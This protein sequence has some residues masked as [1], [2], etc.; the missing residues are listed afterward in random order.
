[1]QSTVDLLKSASNAYYN[2]EEPIMDDDTFDALVDQ[3]REKDPKNPFLKTVG[4]PP[5][6]GV[7]KLPALMPS[8]EKI[9]PGE[10]TLTRFLNLSRDY[11]I[12]EK[13]DGLSALWCPATKG[14]FL[15]GDGVNGQTISHIAPSISSL[16][17]SGEP[18]IIRGELVLRKDAVGL[19][20][21]P[22]RT[23]INGLVHKS[24]PDPALLSQVK[25]LAYEVISP[26]GMKRS[27]QFVWLQGEGFMVP[28]WMGVR[29]T[30][31][32]LK[33]LFTVRRASS[34]YD[35]DG[36][37]VGIDRIP[38]KT[39]TS[40]KPPKDCV[41]FK[42]PVSDQ[43]AITTVEEV[44]WAPSA[45]GYLIPRIRIQPVQIGGARIEFCTGHNARTIVDKGIGPGA[46][47]KVRRS[48]DVIPTL[49]SV[50]LGVNGSLP[51]GYDWEWV[52]GATA[53]GATVSGASTE[54]THIRLVG[55]SPDQ[56]ASQL[57][58]FAKTIDIPGLGP[59][60]C[61]ALIEAGITAPATLWSQ[62]PEQLAKVLGPKS[63]PTLHTNLR[64]KLLNPA[65][66]ELTLLV[67]SNKMPRSTG[68]TKLTALLLAEPNMSKWVTMT[69]VPQGWTEDT[70]QA[71]QA[72]FPAYE[73]WRRT[74]L[75]FLP[76]PL[77]APVSTP[78]KSVCFTGFRDKALEESASKHFQI[79]A[80]VSSKLTVLVI[81]DGSA[82]HESEKVKKA[83]A[84]G[85][86]I[87]QCSE[88][89]RKYLI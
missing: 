88:F 63:G 45:Q 31:E 58:L 49:D 46:Q 12:S 44:I 40:P 67:A 9:K 5:Q 23:V 14:L 71:F 76:Y 77:S 78:T 27:A 60:N 47:I 26:P 32:N 50:L 29:P 7:V 84:L 33:E 16:V 11:V 69:T 10:S 38:I 42:M 2:G 39:L 74:E 65:L 30:E 1:M 48:G 73:A 18:W 57:H 20:T 28:W 17:P 87:L 54:A 41:A 64:N 35:T 85:T 86:E 51:T 56:L 82:N 24:S 75:K 43:S 83:R 6:E 4:S 81:P 15:R 70:F 55:E 34:A 79:V 8:L 21:T 36:I 19:G 37:V 66:T 61:K 53:S 62:T 89:T 59:A 52:S 3:L 25:F 22:A 13:L 72:V 68:E 80:T